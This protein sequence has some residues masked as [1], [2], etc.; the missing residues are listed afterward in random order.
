M[1][2]IEAAPARMTTDPSEIQ[3]FERLAAEWWNPDGPFRPLHRFNPVRLGYIRDVLC[4]TLA[5]DPRAPKPLS[6]LRLL[7]VGC[8]GGL[9]SEP[10]ARLGADVI[11]LDP[12]PT[13][14][15]VARLHA[16]QSGLTI[17]YRVGTVETVAA[18]ES[19]DVV[20]A[21]EVVEHVPDRDAFIAACAATLK[22]G[23]ILFVAT[24]NRTA[25]AFA[26]AIVGA[27]YV[28][29]WL[30]RGTHRYDMLV[31]PVELEGALR[32]AGLAILQRQGVVY[33][34]LTGAWVRSSDMGVNYVIVA[35][36]PPSTPEAGAPT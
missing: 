14:I 36:R 34:P 18:G 3:K 10:M 28:L 25:R 7:D 6:G 1:P 33:N 4:D 9:L 20:L 11:G 5:R 21:M 22:P 27:E 26:L 13:N 8:G 17:D 29:G 35:T 12:A 19:F 31:R 15:E 32:R 2:M 16:A 30:P 23:G 24:I